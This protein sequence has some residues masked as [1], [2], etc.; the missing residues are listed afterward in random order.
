VPRSQFTLNDFT[1]GM[2]TKSSPRD[3]AVNETVESDNVITSYKGLVKSSSIATAKVSGSTTLTHD[4]TG[5]GA[6]I[7]N[8]ENNLDLSGT[9]T[10]GIQVITHPTQNGNGKTTIDFFSRNFGST[11]NFT[12]LNGTQASKQLNG[13]TNN[14]LNMVGNLNDSATSITVDDSSVFNVGDFIQINSE[15]MEITAIG[16]D[17]AMTVVRACKSTSEAAHNN[18][19]PILEVDPSINMGTTNQVEPVYYYV[20]G[21]LYVSDK[22]VV[23][24]DNSSTPKS[25][26]YIDEDRFNTT[27]ISEWINGNADIETTTDAIFETLH[28]DGTNL[29]SQPSAAGEFIMTLKQFDSYTSSTAVTSDGSN[30]VTLNGAIDFD[31][32]TLTVQASSGTANNNLTTGTIFLIGNEAM[33]VENRV[34]STIIQVSRNVLGNATSLEHPD[35][36]GLIQQT[37]DAITGGGWTEGDYEFT[38]SLIDYNDN[39]SLPHTFSTPLS[40]ATIGIGKYFADVGIRINTSETFRKT[41]KGFR[42]YTRKKNTNDKLILFLDVD[43]DRGV[44]RNFFEEYTSWN[45]SNTYGD[46]ADAF[47]KVENINIINPSLETYESINGYSQEEKSISFGTGGYKCA[48]VCASRAW[49]ANVKKNGEKYNDR[50]YYTLPNR[51]TTFPD[52]FFLDIGIN[53]G[54]SFTALHSLGNRLLAFK[55]KKLYVV[56]ISS[57]SEAGWYLEGEF[58]GM[59]CISQEAVTKTP[60]GV[61]WVNNHGVYMFSGSS[62]PVELTVKL[63]DKTWYDGQV[64]SGAQLKPSI[65]YN[66]KYKQLLVFQDSAMTTNGSVTTEEEIFVFDFV[67]QSWSTTSIIVASG[68]ILSEGGVTATQVSNFVE[69]FDGVFFFE[70]LNNNKKNLA[71]FTG[72]HGTNAIS[73]T[74]KDLDFE[75]PGLKKKIFNVIITVKDFGLN[76]SLN[77]SYALDGSTSFT[78]IGAQ[79][80]NSAQY[81]VKTF[82]VGQDCQSISLKITSTGKVEINDVTIEYRLSRRRVT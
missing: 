48:T 2:N 53:D 66:N 67:T 42:I 75:N 81:D 10:Q 34:G 29:N 35:G 78:S 22:K 33:Q 16:V 11:G 26:Q 6:F 20:N 70:G 15:V 4:A 65:G 28:V 59:G 36:A 82:T 71:I 1:G 7:F 74:T 27:T 14:L 80:I 46:S 25:F 44:R 19:D 60:F 54:D 31:T 79:T 45:V 68:G 52:T 21:V 18:N 32:T 37:E 9:L 40:S 51:Y 41:E 17:N 47:A 50:I 72:D 76:R 49:V 77:V 43:Y 8:S 58:E 63:D 12:H 56:N 57:T 5:N 30:A 55:Q 61:C 39:E 69:S 24:G 23:D 64:L 62:A 38:Y 73:F 13:S 3:I